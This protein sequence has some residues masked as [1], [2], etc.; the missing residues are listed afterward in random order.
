MPI[1]NFTVYFFL[2]CFFLH[3]SKIIVGKNFYELGQANWGAVYKYSDESSIRN[4]LVTT[5]GTVRSQAKKNV[6]INQEY[7]FEID[8]SEDNTTFKII[9]VLIVVFRE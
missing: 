7:E 8:I 6:S 1:F 2:K 4:Y 5:F 9:I 3:L